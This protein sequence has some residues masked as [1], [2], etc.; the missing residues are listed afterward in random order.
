MFGVESRDSSDA[1]VPAVSVAAATASSNVLDESVVARSSAPSTPLGRVAGAGLWRRSGRG[2]GLALGGGGRERELGGEW[3]C[4]S[5]LRWS[6]AT[7]AHAVDYCRPYPQD[8]RHRGLH[9][10]PTKRFESDARRVTTRLGHQ[11]SREWL[12]K[13]SRLGAASDGAAD[14]PSSAAAQGKTSLDERCARHELAGGRRA[15]KV[16]RFRRCKDG[17]PKSE[18]RRLRGDPRGVGSGRRGSGR[19]PSHQTRGVGCARWSGQ[20][21]C[22]HPALKRAATKWESTK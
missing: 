6:A 11:A 7:A 13:V 20:P 18:C 17:A 21:A 3:G 19:S 2:W 1:G 14:L 9:A 22:H 12:C 16:L 8:L 4:S 10:R 15:A 5:G